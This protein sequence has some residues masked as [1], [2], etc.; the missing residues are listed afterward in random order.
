MAPNFRPGCMS[1][2][3]MQELTIRLTAALM[4][5]LFSG[6]AAQ[7]ESMENDAV[8]DFIA[9]AELEALDAVRFRDQFS[10]RPLADRYALVKARG[11]Q[12]LVVFRRRCHELYGS[13][14]QPDTRY[15]GK[16]LRAGADTI[17]GCRIDQIF[18]VD[19]SQAEEL[20]LLANRLEDE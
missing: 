11:D 2:S 1:N 10:T 18:S 6:C 15:D 9:V 17:R 7:P 13:T 14:F 19:E 16:V 20:K 4:V 12:Y 8:S 5:A 3:T